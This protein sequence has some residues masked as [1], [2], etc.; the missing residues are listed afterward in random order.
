MTG[1]HAILSWIIQSILDH[2]WI[3]R[4]E[5]N[6][7]C[8]SVYGFFIH[9]RPATCGLGH[10]LPLGTMDTG[11]SS[12]L[13]A[14]FLATHSTCDAGI[15]VIDIGHLHGCE[16]NLSSFCNACIGNSS[17]RGRFELWSSTCIEWRKE[18]GPI[19]APIRA[20]IET[21]CVYRHL[22]IQICTHSKHCE[23]LYMNDVPQY[24][25][26]DSETDPGT[27]QETGTYTAT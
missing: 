6:S 19:R 17:S 4:A 1:L 26:T 15:A 21:V 12:G 25:A 8:N 3:R 2:S 7:A 16:N 24:S 13:E 9:R 23:L 27:D 22:R 11:G 18:R 10:A 14:S 20:V 5:D